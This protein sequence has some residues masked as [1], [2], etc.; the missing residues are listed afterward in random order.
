MK[1]V[2]HP[3]VV[4]CLP[5]CST[6]HNY[7]ATTYLAVGTPHRLKIGQ[8]WIIV[9]MKIITYEMQIL[10][11]Y[12]SGHVVKIWRS[13]W[14]WYKLC[15]PLHDIYRAYSESNYMDRSRT[16]SVLGVTRG[17]AWTPDISLKQQ[18]MQRETDESLAASDLCRVSNSDSPTT[19]HSTVT[20]FSRFHRSQPTMAL[21]RG[22]I[23]QQNWIKAK[24]E[25]SEFSVS[26]FDYTP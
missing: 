8:V 7:S 6:L 18:V 19:S 23:K 2:L 13:Y 25:E 14:L 20:H 12:S 15:N 22:G 3:D 10:Y 21:E 11:S 17:V 16:A 1:L 26:L 4:L 9:R 5:K 24:G